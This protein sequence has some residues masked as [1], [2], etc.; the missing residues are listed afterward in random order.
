MVNPWIH[1]SVYELDSGYISP[2]P[3]LSCLTK[4]VLGWQLCFS[5]PR[6]PPF[7]NMFILKTQGGGSCLTE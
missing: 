1:K 7:K 3:S 2:A 5:I 6:L 4:Q